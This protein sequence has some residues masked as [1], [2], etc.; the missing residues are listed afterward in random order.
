MENRATRWMAAYMEQ[1]HISAEVIADVVGIPAEKLCAGTSQSLDADELL[2]LCEYL[3][4]NPR[5]IPID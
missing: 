1:N 5:E 2:R 4:I 3:H